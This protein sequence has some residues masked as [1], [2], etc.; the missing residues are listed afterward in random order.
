MEATQTFKTQKAI[1]I[2]QPN[3]IT[4]HFSNI[5]HR[6]LSAD[7]S[8]FT[9][10]FAPTN[11]TDEDSDRS[12][13][14]SFSSDEDTESSPLFQQQLVENPFKPNFAQ[15]TQIDAGSMIWQN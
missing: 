15:V 12:I 1:N 13:D 14:I 10:E 4:F 2:L 11:S 5:D 6:S 3:S 7:L 8:Q 9:N